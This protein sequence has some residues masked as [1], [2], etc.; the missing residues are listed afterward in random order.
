MRAKRSPGAVKWLAAIPISAPTAMAS[1]TAVANRKRAP[2]R[3]SET[4]PAATV[5]S[6]N[7]AA[8]SGGSASRNDLA[9]PATMRFA[10]NTAKGDAAPTRMSAAMTT[11]SLSKPNLTMRA[12]WATEADKGKLRTTLSRRGA[13]PSPANNYFKK[14]FVLRKSSATPLA[15]SPP[16]WTRA[17][18]SCSVVRS[19]ASKIGF[20]ISAILGLAFSVASR[21]IGAGR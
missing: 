4:A 9:S 6:A 16:T 11:P 17:L 8:A 3:K 5:A 19:S 20:K 15:G 14:P 7:R 21:M 12:V 1:P 18:S 2:V 10:R 13:C